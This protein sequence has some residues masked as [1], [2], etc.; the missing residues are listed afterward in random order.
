MAIQTWK[1]IDQE[2]DREENGVMISNIGKGQLSLEK[3]NIDN[4]EESSRKATSN[5]GG[6]QSR[7]K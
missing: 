4:R 5:N 1:D 6:T 2:V 7:Y 3:R